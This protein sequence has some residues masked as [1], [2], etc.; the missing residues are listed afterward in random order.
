MKENI[1]R[2][3]K[4][5]IHIPIRFRLLAC[6]ICPDT[7]QA[8]VCLWNGDEIRELHLVHECKS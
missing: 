8:G 5:I 4:H 7:V 2:K 6:Q 1:F 3:W